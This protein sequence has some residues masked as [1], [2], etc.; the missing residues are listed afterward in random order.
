MTSKISNKETL[1]N[2]R[3]KE[4]IDNLQL[5]GI[6]LEE[7]DMDCAICSKFVHNKNSCSIHTIIE[8]IIELKFLEDNTDYCH[9]FLTLLYFYTLNKL[10][11]VY[12]G[13]LWRKL[14]E[15]YTGEHPRKSAFDVYDKPGIKMVKNFFSKIKGNDCKQILH[16]IIK[17]NFPRLSIQIIKEI[18]VKAITFAIKKYSKKFGGKPVDI[19][20]SL[21]KYMSK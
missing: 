3:K 14:F 2:N 18:E 10:T 6:N 15:Q 5:Y 9:N 8:H 20:I 17:I 13:K 12:T 1:Y 19:P 11:Y 16:E 4:I 7:V 21:L